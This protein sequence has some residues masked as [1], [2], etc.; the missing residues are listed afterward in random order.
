MPLDSAFW[1]RATQQLRPH[2]EEALG[3]V[4]LQRA[5]GDCVARLFQKIQEVGV[6]PSQA[7]IFL[8]HQR[9]L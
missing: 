6:A 2:L 5:T 1:R 4:A 7:A 3:E 9:L 8:H